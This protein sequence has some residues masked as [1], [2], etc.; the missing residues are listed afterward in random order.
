MTNVTHNTT[1]TELLADARYLMGKLN[2]HQLSGRL[3]DLSTDT[4]G[5]LVNGWWSELR[6]R[7]ADQQVVAVKEV[8]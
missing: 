2:R 7:Q 5:H 3:T 4:L 6:Q 1:R 8:K